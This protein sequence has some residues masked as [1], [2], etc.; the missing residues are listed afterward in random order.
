MWWAEEDT[1]CCSEK[2]CDLMP[3]A[4]VWISVFAGFMVLYTKMLLPFDNQDVIV[5]LL[6]HKDVLNSSVL[7]I[8]ELN[9]GAFLVKC[10][11]LN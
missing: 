4:S 10:E 11:Q 9:F 5:V 7:D 8:P 3:W 2:V 1:M 6:F